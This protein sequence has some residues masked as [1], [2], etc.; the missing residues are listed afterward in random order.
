MP[1]YTP[2][3]LSE[4]DGNDNRVS[5]NSINH[6][7]PIDPHQGLKQEGQTTSQ[8]KISRHYS[9]KNL[10]LIEIPTLIVGRTKR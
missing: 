6:G 10:P 7:T 1:S 3:S 9:S 8:P 5:V 2:V 4:M